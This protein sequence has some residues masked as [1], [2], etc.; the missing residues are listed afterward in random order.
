MKAWHVHTPAL[1]EPDSLLIFAATA[2]RA[3]YMALHAG[4]WDYN[5]CEIRANRAK[6]Y[7]NLFDCEQVIETNDDLP[8]GAEPFY[9]E[10]ECSFCGVFIKGDHYHSFGG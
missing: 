8:E 7:D 5:Y 2:N 6:K 4:L 1:Y 3:K 10:E 9:E